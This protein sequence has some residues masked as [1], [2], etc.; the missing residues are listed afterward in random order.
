MTVLST[1]AIR[2]RMDSPLDRRLVITPILDFDE[3]A[4]SGQAAIDLRLGCNFCLSAP[5]AFGCIDEFSDNWSSVHFQKLYPK[6]YI[7][8]GSHIIIHPHQFILAQS[9]EYIRLPADLMAY[10]VGRSTWGRLGLIV[11]TAVGIHPGFA[12]NLTLELRNLGETPLALY[13]GQTVAQLFIETVVNEDGA[14][15]S[16]YSNSAQYTG[17]VDMVPRKISSSK[18]SGILKSLI[19]EFNSIMNN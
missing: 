13:P 2:K 18:T 5:S 10:V 4:K 6:E 16:V 1:D 9:L 12:G 17:S 11:A 15:S 19:D 14:A 8:L 7:P 3:Q